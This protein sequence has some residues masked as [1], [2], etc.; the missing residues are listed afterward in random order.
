[1]DAQ[2]TKSMS[3]VTNVEKIVRN[4]GRIVEE[5]HHLSDAFVPEVTKESTA[6]VSKIPIVLARKTKNTVLRMIA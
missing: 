2:K 3:T 5:N 4:H 6:S 1:M